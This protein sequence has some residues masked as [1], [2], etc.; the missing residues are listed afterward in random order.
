M[1]S[2]TPR[3]ISVPPLV[4]VTQGQHIPNPRSKLRHYTETSLSV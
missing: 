1:H 3:W 2:A 4:E